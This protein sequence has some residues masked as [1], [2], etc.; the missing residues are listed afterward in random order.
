VLY[1]VEAFGGAVPAMSLNSIF[2]LGGFV[3]AIIIGAVLYIIYY[4]EIHD[5]DS[6]DRLDHYGGNT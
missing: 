5:F 4:D 2:I 6:K 1:L 3:G